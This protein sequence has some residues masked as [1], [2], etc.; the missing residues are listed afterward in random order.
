VSTGFA[1]RNNA[2][3]ASAQQAVCHGGCVVFVGVREG[4]RRGISTVYTIAL[5]V[6]RDTFKTV[7]ICSIYNQTTKNH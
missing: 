3:K 4:E 1:R 5:I 2:G 7:I 6:S